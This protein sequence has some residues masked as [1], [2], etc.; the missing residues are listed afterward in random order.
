LL[1][2]SELQQDLLIHQI[3]HLKGK[4]ND[5]LKDQFNNPLNNKSKNFKQF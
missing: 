5:S 2:T 1:G 4:E 3:P